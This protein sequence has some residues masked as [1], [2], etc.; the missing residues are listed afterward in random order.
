MGNETNA[1]RTKVR[2]SVQFDV[3]TIRIMQLDNIEF[4][5]DSHDEAKGS[6]IDAALVK[7]YV[8]HLLEDG[9]LDPYEGDEHSSEECLDDDIREVV[10]F[11][12]IKPKSS[13]R[14]V[15]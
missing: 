5:L 10:S 12:I 6:L 13:F 2:C 7:E 8:S 9:K 11:E 3:S 14:K 15:H 4:Y 1:G